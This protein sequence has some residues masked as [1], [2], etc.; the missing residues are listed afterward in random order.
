MSHLVFVV[1]LNFTAA[2]LLWYTIVFVVTV[3]APT[4]YH[5]KDSADSFGEPV[6]DAQCPCNAIAFSDCGDMLPFSST[7][8]A[9]AEVHDCREFRIS[10]DEHF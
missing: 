2:F 3:T 8:W 10:G 6:G 1:S 5:S 7:I 4:G 9:M